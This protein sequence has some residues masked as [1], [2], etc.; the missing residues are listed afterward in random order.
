[1]KKLLAL[2]FFI[3]CYSS[4]GQNYQVHG[5][6]MY[7][8]TRYIQWPDEYNTG[9]FE[10][11]VLGDSPITEE[12]KKLAEMKKVGDRAIKVTRVA[13]ANDIKK[14]NILFVPA[15]KSPQLTEILVK[16]GTKSTLVVTELPG[17]GAKGSA[18]NFI[19]K[20]GKLAFELNQGVLAKQRLKASNELTR[21]AIII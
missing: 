15:D 2:I 9:D 6:Y 21:L 11:S 7:S 16:V 8:F 13:S 14:C 5:V 19:S 1:M 10:I 17:L 18:V 3:V 20:D 12:L 4:Y